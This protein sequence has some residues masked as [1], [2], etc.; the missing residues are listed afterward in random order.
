MYSDQEFIRQLLKSCNARRKPFQILMQK[1]ENTR[2][3]INIGT[4][5]PEII[6]FAILSCFDDAIEEFTTYPAFKCTPGNTIKKLRRRL[7]SMAGVCRIFYTFVKNVLDT[8]IITNSTISFRYFTTQHI[9]RFQIDVMLMST[10][11]KL[12]TPQVGLKYEDARLAYAIATMRIYSVTHFEKLAHTRAYSRENER[13]YWRNI[14]KN[15][16]CAAFSDEFSL[17]HIVTYILLSGFPCQLNNRA[18]KYHGQKYLYDEY[19]Y[20][21]YTDFIYYRE[22]AIIVFLSMVGFLCETSFNVLCVVT[23][24]YLIQ[25]NYFVSFVCIVI[26]W[27]LQYTIRMN[28]RYFGKIDV[29]I[30]IFVLIDIYLVMSIIFI[31]LEFTP[32]HPTNAV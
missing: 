26:T 27:T 8:Y 21:K 2:A 24:S 1:K 20:E 13:L 9:N 28:L 11:G 31:V 12:S 6:I 14:W 25:N 23:G 17:T 22:A 3:L 29:V 7:I 10:H 32:Q 4:F 19:K 16:I 18:K 15:R 5:L 30:L